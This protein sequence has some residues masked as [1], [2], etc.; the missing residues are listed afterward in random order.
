MSRG[1]QALRIPKVYLRLSLKESIPGTTFS[2]ANTYTHT[3]VREHAHVFPLFIQ[4]Q[5]YS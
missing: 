3:H 1:G 4:G 5:I 2:L